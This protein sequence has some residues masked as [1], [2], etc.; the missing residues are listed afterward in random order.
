MNQVNT[1]ST[2]V[3]VTAN[4]LAD[5]RSAIE[6]RTKILRAREAQLR[7]TFLAEAQKHQQPAGF[8][9]VL[10]ADQVGQLLETEQTLIAQLA[11]LASNPPA[12]SET[13]KNELATV[14]SFNAVLLRAALDGTPFPVQEKQRHLEAYAWDYDCEQMEGKKRA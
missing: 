7:E 10:F 12:L 8:I 9:R 2:R 11:E 13:Q 4:A 5:E 1:L 14:L 6:Q 3:F